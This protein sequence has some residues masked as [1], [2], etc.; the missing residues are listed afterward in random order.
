MPAIILAIGVVGIIKM[1]L[2]PHAWMELMQTSRLS[3]FNSR[4]LTRLHHRSKRGYISGA[5]TRL[6]GT[7]IL[8]L[9][10]DPPPPKHC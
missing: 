5:Q 10:R 7:P 6:M 2:R 9:K 1:S 8:Q 3:L 4:L